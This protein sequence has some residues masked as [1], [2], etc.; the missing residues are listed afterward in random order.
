[1]SSKQQNNSGI[2]ITREMVKSVK[3]SRMLYT[4]ALESAKKV[5]M[6]QL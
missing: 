2:P 4:D 3:S 5:K 1:M 6:Y